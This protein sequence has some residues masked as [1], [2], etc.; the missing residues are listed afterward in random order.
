MA[1]TFDKVRGHTIFLPGLRPTPSVLDLG[2]NHGEFSR[3][4]NE[5]FP[6]SYYLVEANPTLAEEVGRSSPFVVWNC[7]VSPSG[8]VIPFHLASNDEASSVLPLPEASEYDATAVGTVL[9]RAAS[10]D[11]LRSS[12]PAG[13]LDLLKVDIE[14]AEAAM[15]LAASAETLRSFRQMTVEFHSHA[16]FGY[17]IER[18][19]EQ[20]IRKLRGLGFLALDFSGGRRTNVLFLNRRALGISR[21]DELGWRLRQDPPPFLLALWGLIPTGVKRWT[22]AAIDRWT[23]KM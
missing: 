3:L 5:R 15:F 20:V 12:L 13:P 8:G 19:V 4:L 6:G 11:E 9:V 17:G 22:R 14:G 18:Q 16:S 2:A 23:G 1:V 7:A 21:L 10:L